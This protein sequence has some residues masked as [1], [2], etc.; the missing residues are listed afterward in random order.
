MLLPKK[1]KLLLVFLIIS[2]T[3]VVG[4]S[5]SNLTFKAGLSFSKFKKTSSNVMPWNEPVHILS[6]PT[7][8]ATY[9]LPLLSSRWTGDI[10]LCINTR[11]GKSDLFTERNFWIAYLQVPL[12]VSLNPSLLGGKWSYS[13]STAFVPSLDIATSQGMFKGNSFDESRLRY[14]DMEVWLGGAIFKG[15]WGLNIQ[16]CHGLKT[17][18]R[19]ENYYSLKNRAVNLMLSYKIGKSKQT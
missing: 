7:F 18:S 19:F 15:S 3:S 17:I 16:Y 9:Q 6:G 2:L 5:Q 1:I 11:G 12:G 10:G 4:I 8:G 13:F 14:H